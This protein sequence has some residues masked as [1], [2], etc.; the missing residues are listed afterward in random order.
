MAF[1]ETGCGKNDP[2]CG[3]FT[4]ILRETLTVID[5]IGQAGGL[6]VITEALFMPT[7]EPALQRRRRSA[8]Q[9]SSAIGFQVR[10]S[11]VVGTD[12]IGVSF[13][14]RF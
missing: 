6:L 11:P 12:S 4:I 10:A 14:G 13:L 7:R 8:R 9:R 3:I 1:G 5:A 2:D